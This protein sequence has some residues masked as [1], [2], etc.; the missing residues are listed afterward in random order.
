M[1]LALLFVSP[2][3]LLFGWTLLDLLR[4]PL[5]LFW[6]SGAYAL[7]GGPIDTGS[8][9]FLGRGLLCFRSRRLGMGSSR[10]YRISQGNE[11]HCAQ[12]FFNSS[13][14]PVPPLRRR[15]K[16]VADVLEGIRSIGFTQSRWDVFIRYWGVACRHGPCGPIS[17][18][19]P[20][21][22]GFLLIY[23]VSTSGFL[24]PLRC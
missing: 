13:L 9:A 17:S 24:A 16:S 10:L 3:G 14:S 12:F 18:L 23:M 15:F 6:M 20:G 8:S 11:V 2:F 1:L 4:C 7:A 5:V 21:I 19:H 22:I